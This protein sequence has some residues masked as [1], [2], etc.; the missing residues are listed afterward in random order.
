MT[1][2]EMPPVAGTTNGA[3]TKK[4]P[5]FKLNF[6]TN[7]PKPTQDSSARTNIILLDEAPKVMRRPLQLM[8]GRAYSAVWPYVQIEQFESVDDKGIVT[9]LTQPKII[10]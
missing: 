9:K 2:K 10:K 8:D 1:E 5:L 7:K 4:E 3:Q 6:S